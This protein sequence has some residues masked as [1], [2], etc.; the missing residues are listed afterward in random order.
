MHQ[1][2]IEITRTEVIDVVVDETTRIAQRTQLNAEREK[3]AQIAAAEGEKRSMEL[4][5]DAELYT[6]KQ[7]AEGIRAIPEAE[8]YQTEIIAKANFNKGEP[9]INFENLKNSKYP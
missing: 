6:A 3:R 4:G 9:A 7:R 2:G 8:A 5:A 1:R